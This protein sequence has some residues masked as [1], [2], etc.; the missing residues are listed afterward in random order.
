MEACMPSWILYC[1]CSSFHE[2]HL[3]MYWSA[4]IMFAYICMQGVNH[5]ELQIY[6]SASSLHAVYYYDFSFFQ[7][8]GCQN[9]VSAHLILIERSSTLW[10]VATTTAGI[11]ESLNFPYSVKSARVR[12]S[13][14][15]SS[16]IATI[17]KH[18]CQ[19]KS[20]LN[21][22]QNHDTLF[23]SMIS[24]TAHWGLKS[25]PIICKALLWLRPPGLIFL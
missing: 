5:F 9:H 4:H 10:Y 19:S 21:F 12:L 6:S 23:S 24:V 8:N 1:A 3:C 13:R 18:T 2:Y 25:L 22:L 15:R 7:I 20:R 17:K 11:G 14:S 16:P